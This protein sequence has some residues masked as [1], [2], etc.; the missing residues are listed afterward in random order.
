MKR[1]PRLRRM[2]GQ[3][4]KFEPGHWELADYWGIWIARQATG[5]WHI[6]NCR[7]ETRHWH[8][9]HLGR[10]AFS[11]RTEALEAITVLLVADGLPVRPSAPRPPLRS[12][13]RR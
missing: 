8:S 9:L 4:T 10:Q 11:T 1:L 7:D 5:C 2:R 3:H 6:R 12:A 13:A